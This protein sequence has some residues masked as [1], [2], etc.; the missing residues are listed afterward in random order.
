MTEIV[1]LIDE[2]DDRLHR[3]GDHLFETREIHAIREIS[4]PA[5]LTSIA[6]AATRET[7]LLPQD[8]PILTHRRSALDHLIVAAESYEGEVVLPVVDEISTM[9][10]ETGTTIHV[11]AHQ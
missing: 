8:Q 10:I 6:R 1:T 3:Y 4:V 7:V 5:I 9:T 2:R 11:T